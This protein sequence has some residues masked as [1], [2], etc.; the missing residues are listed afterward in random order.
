MAAG[1]HGA[2]LVLEDLHWAD[3]ETL[4]IVEYLADNLAEQRV[5]CLVNV[6]DDERSPGLALGWFLH[7]RRVSRLLPIAPLDEQEV[8]A[9]AASCLGAVAVPDEVVAFAAR[10]DGVPFVVEEL[11]A[12]ALSS[13]A[14]TVEEG[15]WRIS[16][17]VDAVVPL[18]CSE[19]M[20]RRVARLGPRGRA[21]LLAAA[22]LG[23]RF[24]RSLLPAMTGLGDAA[25]L[26]AL[27][28]AV[29]AQIVVSDRRNPSFFFRHALS[30]D[31]VLA[32]LFPPE[33]EALSR[34]ALQ[35]VEEAHPVL[36]DDWF[37][38]AAELALGSGDRDRGRGATLLL[39][40]AR[41]AF[42]RGA[43]A[44]AEAILDRAHGLLPEDD[45]TS[46]DVDEFLLQVLSLA[47]SASEQWG[48][49]F[50]AGAAA[51]GGPPSAGARRR[52]GDTVGR[53]ARA[54]ARERPGVCRAPQPPVVTLTPARVMAGVFGSGRARS[55]GPVP[56]WSRRWRPAFGLSTA[57][58]PGPG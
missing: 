41:G 12:A 5:L 45:P 35:A 40:M 15:R 17:R 56:A 9:M 53:G 2:L 29:D 10:A 42:R 30:R 21:V 32:E 47:A 27:H 36:S 22:V 50:P 55:A 44:T 4:T 14:L 7:A 58:C 31:A 37:G 51:G 16:D 39:Q 23:R 26:S 52:R 46:R 3:P 25:V 13:G 54:P 38:L 33:L 24:D 18:T 6:R 57:G 19:S 48:G 34:R 28:E 49:D 8:A 11:L 1:N 20:R 43:L